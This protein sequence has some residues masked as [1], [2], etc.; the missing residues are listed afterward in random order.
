MS[1]SP[2]DSLKFQRSEHPPLLVTYRSC[3]AA[4][5]VTGDSPARIEAVAFVHAVSRPRLFIPQ[6]CYCTR[7]MPPPIIFE[8]LFRPWWQ[9]LAASLS[10]NV[11]WVVYYPQY[12]LTKAAEPELKTTTR[13]LKINYSPSIAISYTIGSLQPKVMMSVPSEPFL[14]AEELK[15][16]RLIM[17]S[18]II[19]T[20][21]CLAL[22]RRFR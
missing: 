15:I 5:L 6:V 9:L 11:L 3:I 22:T 20:H 2:S 8:T 10:Q 1:F 4:P 13:A 14:T 12:I 7:P 16:S 21:C 18:S 19:I 17:S